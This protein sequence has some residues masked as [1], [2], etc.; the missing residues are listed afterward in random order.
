MKCLCRAVEAMDLPAFEGSEE[1]SVVGSGEVDEVEL[2]SLVV[3]VGL[4]VADGVFGGLLVASAACGVGAEEGGG[5]VFDLLLEDGIEFTA[6]NDR[7]GCAGVG[8]GCH[9]SDVCCF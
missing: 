2:E 1:A 7:M 4:R 8:S 6:F 5:V 9:G 3:A